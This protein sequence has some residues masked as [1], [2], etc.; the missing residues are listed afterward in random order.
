MKNR[1]P[2]KFIAHQK[3][4]LAN[5]FGATMTLWIPDDSMSRYKPKVCL[6]LKHGKGAISLVFD[7]VE[8]LTD[9]LNGMAIFAE[10]NGD[11][12]RK[13]LVEALEDWTTLKNESRRLKER[14][15]GLKLVK[16]DGHHV[17]IINE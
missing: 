5:N 12:M 6:T 15:R 7:D 9:A 8:G 11:S 14:R 3:I 13:S 4:D 17:K 1:L 10:E 16:H 2:K